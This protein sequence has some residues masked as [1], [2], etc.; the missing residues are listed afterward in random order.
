M[1]S[2]DT[3]AHT[4]TGPVS[5][6]CGVFE[7]FIQR[8]THRDVR[9]INDMMARTYSW[10][11]MEVVVQSPDV[12]KLKKD[13]L[14]RK[15]KNSKGVLVFHKNRFLC[16][17]WTNKLQNFLTCLVRRVQRLVK[18]SIGVIGTDTGFKYLCGAEERRG[19]EMPH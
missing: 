2:N 6:F 1:Q 13:G 10:G 14:P 3:V 8:A 5:T 12:Q 16:P 15:M 17:S 18:T 11:R 19:S 4:C 7:G 9:S